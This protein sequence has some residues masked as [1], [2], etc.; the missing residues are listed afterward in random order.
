MKKICHCDQV[1]ANPVEQ[2]GASRSKMRLLI[3]PDDGAP[4][5]AMRQFELEPGGHTP[6]HTHD[7]EHEMYILQGTAT[8]TVEGQEHITRPGCCAFVPPNAMHQVTNTG[9]IQL[10]FLCLIPVE[11]SCGCPVKTR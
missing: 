5:F 4:T 9:L 10:K 8:I 6:L 1:P 11:C 2:P 7:W 3:G